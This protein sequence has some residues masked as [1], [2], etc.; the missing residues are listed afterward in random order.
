MEG[1]TTD[2]QRQHTR[3]RSSF[4]G[5]AFEKVGGVSGGDPDAGRGEAIEGSIS[6]RM[7]V[8]TVDD[9]QMIIINEFA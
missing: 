5:T 7:Q 6:H 3:S 8:D 1:C 2:E 9:L 4:G